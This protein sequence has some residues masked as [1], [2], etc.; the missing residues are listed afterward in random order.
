MNKYIALLRGINVGGKN[1]VEMKKL[2]TTFENADFSNVSTYINS[3]N[4]IFESKEK[5]VDKLVSEIKLILKKNFDF[6]IQLIIRSNINIYNLVKAIPDDWQNDTM[7][8]T[9][10]LFLWNDYDNKKSLNLI[11]QTPG[12]DNMVYING[13][14]IWNVKRAEYN[15]SGMRKFI[16]TELYKNMTARN[17]N[18]V[19]KLAELMN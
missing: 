7:Q 3:G 5:K 17:V 2:K 8:K 12:V 19:R 10:V 1:K 4:V 15:R 11:K 16:G 14:I 9:D 18:T 13:A 6:D